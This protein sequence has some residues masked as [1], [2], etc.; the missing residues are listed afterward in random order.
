MGRVVFIDTRCPQHESEAEKTVIE[1]AA[2]AGAAKSAKRHVT[3]YWLVLPST[4]VTVTIWGFR[5]P[6]L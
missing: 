5:G 1:S 4:S 3:K 2:G 6:V